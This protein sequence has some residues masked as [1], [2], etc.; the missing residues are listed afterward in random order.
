MKRSIKYLVYGIITIVMTCSVLFMVSVY[1]GN[2]QNAVTSIED[3]HREEKFV[4]EFKYV[5]E[6]DIIDKKKGVFIWANP[7]N[8]E[9]GT[10]V[11]NA[12]SKPNKKSSE[13]SIFQRSG[14]DISN[15]Y[16]VMSEISDIMVQE[17]TFNN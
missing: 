13:F 14:D 11:Y 9:S 12:R 15:N 2:K 7:N 17:L 4:Q 3:N 8:E 5:K 10:V 6:Y 1:V 16:E